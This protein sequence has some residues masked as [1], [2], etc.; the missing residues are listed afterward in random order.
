[1]KRQ[2]IRIKDAKGVVHLEPNGSH[3]PAS[4]L[5]YCVED[6]SLMPFEPTNEKVT[7]NMCQHEFEVLRDGLKIVNV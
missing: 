7:C 1:M 5:C 6:S 2:I 3:D 4:T